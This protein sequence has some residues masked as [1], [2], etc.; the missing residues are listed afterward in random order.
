MSDNAAKY[1]MYGMISVAVSLVFTVILFLVFQDQSGRYLI[2]SGDE[3]LIDTET[4]TIYKL[5]I[6][7]GEGIK[8]ELLTESVSDSLSNPFPPIKKAEPPATTKTE[9]KPKYTKPVATK[10]IREL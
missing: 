5:N 4:G 10:P 2:P 6:R 1:L 8:W 3:I 9:T 7:N